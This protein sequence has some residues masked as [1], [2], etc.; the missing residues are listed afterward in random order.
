[1]NYALSVFCSVALCM[2]QQRLVKMANGV[3]AVLV[4]DKKAD[5]LENGNVAEDKLAEEP[6]SEMSSPFSL[7][8]EAVSLS[9]TLT[10]W[11]FNHM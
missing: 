3:D 5:T 4:A 2:Q 6:E 11:L 1:M 10:H 7:P 9:H 8:G